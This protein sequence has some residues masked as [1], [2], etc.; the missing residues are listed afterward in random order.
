M[1]GTLIDQLTKAVAGRADVV[2][3]ATVLA[4]RGHD[5]WGFGASPGILLRPRNRYEIADIMRV[6]TEHSI[7]VVPRGGASNCSAGMMPATDRVLLDLSG[8]NQILEVDVANRRARVEPGVIN[9][10]LQAAL[11][12]HGLCFSPDPVSAHLATVAGNIIENAG[13]PHALKYGV[14]YNHVLAVEVVLADGAVIHLSAG[15][16]GPD[17]LGVLIGSEGTLGILTEATVGLRPIAPVTRSLMGSFATARDAAETI[18]AIIETGTV[19]AAVEWLDRA[20]IAGLEQFADSGY[21]TDVDAIVLI[22]IDGTPEQVDRDTE[23]VEQVLRRTAVEVRR[24]DDEDARA[25]LWH[26]RLH[27]FDAVVGSGK[28]FFIGDVTVPRQHIP[29]MQDAIQ[30][31]AARH[32]DALLFIAVTG[33]AGD[34]DLH[35][36]TFFDRDNPNAP[37]AL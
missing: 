13:G 19:P 7:A 26:G 31:A 20:G 30:A 6:A 4:E 11:A 2:T 22:D 16:D 15:D 24:A 17:L 32:S 34:G 14:T 29:D 12:P 35:P 23:I 5:Y 8:L 3:D 33:H 18:S 25:K 9:S 1:N 21:P 10:D 37:A 27:L 28:G 36:T